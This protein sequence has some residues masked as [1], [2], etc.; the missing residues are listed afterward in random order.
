MNPAPY[1]SN[2]RLLAML[3]FLYICVYVCVA[4]LLTSSSALQAAETSVPEGTVDVG[5]TGWAVKRPVLASA[6]PHACPWGELGDFLKSAMA[7]DGYE[8]ILCRN[9]NR[10]RGPRLVATAGRPPAL[11]ALD[12]YVG[13]TTRVDAPVDFGITAAGILAR[14]ASKSHPNL[15]LIARIEDPTYLLVAVKAD[16]GITDLAQIAERRMPVKILAGGG[17]SEVLDYYGLTREAITSWGG[18]FGRAMGARADAEFDVII[19]NLASPAMNPESA[20][21]TRL[22]QAHALRFLDLPQPLR[23]SL[24][25]QPDYELVTAKW[26]LL[27]GVDREIPTVGRTGEVIFAREDTPEQAAYA[28]ARA[29]DRHRRAL[30]WY[31]RPY[32]YEPLTVSQSQGVALHPGAERYYREQGY[33]K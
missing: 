20:Q 23:E 32:S 9:C 2:D 10:D 25:A 19:D 17:S 4:V 33:M 21:W 1:T 5:A 29:I 16:S 3:S 6:C 24:A 12:A 8:V 13:T 22:S 11:D 28:V 15:R 14:A 26:G 7:D 31:V 27:H 30:K 18:S